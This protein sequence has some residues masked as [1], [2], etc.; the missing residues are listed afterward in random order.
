MLM[1][2]SGLYTKKSQAKISNW[3]YRCEKVSWRQ[4]SKGQGPFRNVASRVASVFSV[5]LCVVNYIK[6]S[7][8][9]KN[10]SES[11]LQLLC[12]RPWPGTHSPETKPN[13]HMSGLE[14]VLHVSQ[15]SHLLLNYVS[16]EGRAFLLR[17]LDHKLTHFFFI[18]LKIIF[19]FTYCDYYLQNQDHTLPAVF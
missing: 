4:S 18:F 3:D 19:L 16:F 17:C 9:P 2:S 15:V 14:K 8:G 5:P 1:G 7:H 11:Q 13:P 6:N 10:G 12:H